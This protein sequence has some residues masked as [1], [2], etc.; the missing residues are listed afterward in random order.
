MLMEPIYDSLLRANIPRLVRTPIARKDLPY[1]SHTPNR[2]PKKL[3]I[4]RTK[5][6]LRAWKRPSYR[7]DYT[8]SP[9]LRKNLIP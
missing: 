3:L 9:A 4:T 8:Y 5:A 6:D 1:L 7:M 2:P